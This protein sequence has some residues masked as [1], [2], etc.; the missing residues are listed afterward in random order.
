MDIQLHFIRKGSGFPLVLLHGNG[1]SSSYFAGQM[2]PFAA[3]FCTYA[4]DTRGHGGTPRGSAPFTLAQFADDLLAFLDRQQIE[5]A[6]LLGFSD[7]GNVALLFAL[8]YPQR[9]EKLVLCGANIDPWG[10]KLR[11]QLP[12]VLGY[13]IVAALAPF[14]SGARPKKELL[15]LMVTQPHITAQ[16]LAELHMPTLV[17]AGSRDMIRAS[18]TRRIAAAI[19][20]AQL[21]I[22]PGSH[23]VAAE[24]PPAFNAAVLRF[25]CE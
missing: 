6:H 8:K 18:H 25:L 21:C 22:L 24:D 4:V 19:A 13:G 12:I 7:G 11:Y 10:V 3:R 14:D 20:G 1:E 23:F 2:E 9:V 17:V 16:Q 15:G 5:K